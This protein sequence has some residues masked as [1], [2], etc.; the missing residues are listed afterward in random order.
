MLPGKVT[1][2]EDGVPIPG[3]SVKVKGT[4]AGTITNSKGNY[5][6]SVASGIIPS[7]SYVL[8]ENK[9]LL[10]IP[11]REINLDNLTQNP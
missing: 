11:Q 1:D 2:N 6:L 9:L 8:N 4:T 7:G 10:P 3:V 5:T